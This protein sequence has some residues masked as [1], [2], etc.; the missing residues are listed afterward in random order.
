MN[1]Y[2]GSFTVASVWNNDLKGMTEVTNEE[3]NID[4]FWDKLLDDKYQQYLQEKNESY[5]RGK[6]M[7]KQVSYFPEKFFDE[8][9]QDDS[10]E[11]KQ[12]RKRK[13]DEDSDEEFK[14]K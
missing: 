14:K 2:L 9:D 4:H 5:G 3:E 10:Q 8:P 1:E 13:L 12:G 11:K 7:K 6:R